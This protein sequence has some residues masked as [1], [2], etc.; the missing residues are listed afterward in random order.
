[1]KTVRFKL[2]E[3][4]GVTERIYML[5][6]TPIVL[7]R[8]GRLVFDRDAIWMELGWLRKGEW[9]KT[10]WGPFEELS[11]C[12][13]RADAVAIGIEAITGGTEY[14]VPTP[15]EGAKLEDHRD[16]DSPTRGML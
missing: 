8:Y 14:L 13:A 16:K 11:E 1:M 2:T 3:R 12:V 10:R 4:H 9:L 7:I 6:D 5:D 15:A